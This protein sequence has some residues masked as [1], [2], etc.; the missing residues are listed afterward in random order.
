[1]KLSLL[2][3][4]ALSWVTTAGAAE[5]K[6]ITVKVG[7]EVKLT[8]QYSTTTGYQWV[9]AKP[10]DAK[11]LKLVGT[12]YTRSDPKLAGA[13]GHTVWTFQAQAEGKA[14]IGF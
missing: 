13:G 3:C 6:P 8:L 12:D 1:M 14:E 7:E 10:P 5:P 9:V 2:I 4:L 11:L